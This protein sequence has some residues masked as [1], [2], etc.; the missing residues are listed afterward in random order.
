MTRED[1]AGDRDVRLGDGR[2]VRV[3]RFGPRGRLPIVYLHGFLGSRIE[4]RVAGPLDADIVA[5]DRPGYGGSDPSRPPSLR[6]FAHDLGEVLDALGIDRFAVLGASAGAPY[7]LAV[8][9]TLGPR[10]ARCVLAAGVAGRSAIDAGGGT[11]MLLR[12]M[13]RHLVTV[14]KLLPPTARLALRLGADRPVLDLLFAMG[15]EHFAPGVDRERLS[16]LLIDSLREGTR[17]G[18]DGPLADIEILT[19]PWDVDPTT[20]TTPVLVLHGADD[21]VVPPAHAAW[22][23]STL[24]H[25]RVRIVPRTGHVSLVVNLAGAMVDELAPAPIDSPAPAV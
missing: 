14:R 10:V 3:S 13:R 16:R 22:Y 20:V 8:C 12:Q 24:P 17:R 23:A 15:R 21:L 2:I 18:M 7:A 11:V 4:P 5:P 25:A 9:A 1:E 19:K 6:R